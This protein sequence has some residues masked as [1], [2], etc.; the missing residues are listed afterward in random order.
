MAFAPCLAGL[1]DFLTR[2]GWQPL[3]LK[4]ISY[5][6]LTDFYCNR[7]ISY[8]SNHWNKWASLEI[9]LMKFYLLRMKYF[10]KMKWDNNSKRILEFL[11]F[12]KNFRLYI[13]FKL[14]YMYFYIIYGSKNFLI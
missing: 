13:I 11:F 2:E 8:Q 14:L 10:S 9:L 3:G 4:I 6:V 5:S 12:S 1:V 7:Q